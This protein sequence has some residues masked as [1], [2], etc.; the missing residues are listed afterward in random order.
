MDPTD[1]ATLYIKGTPAVS[2]NNCFV[3]NNST[4]SSGTDL[5]GAANLTTSLLTTPGNY[6]I[7]GAATLNATTILTGAAPTPD[8][9]ASL[10]TPGAGIC[11]TYSGGSTLTPG[12]YCGGIT[13]NNGT[14]LMLSAG[15]YV[16]NGGDFK[17]N[18]NATIDGSAGV[19]LIFINGA[20]FHFN[21]G[22]AMTLNAPAGGTYKGVAIY[23]DRADANANADVINGTA[24]ITINGALYAPSQSVTYSGTSVS[25][26]CTQLIAYTITFAGTSNFGYSASCPGGVG[27]LYSSASGIF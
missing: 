24:N 7:K 2:T 27:T 13:V 10:P 5:Q 4:S 16:V 18:G 23:V 6:A 9:F 26:P 14:N 20:T 3:G 8:P 1:A 22:G 19:T 15:T 25:T 12:T 21:G 17:L 11:Q